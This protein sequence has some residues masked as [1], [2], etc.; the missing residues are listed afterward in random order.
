[1]SQSTIA[2]PTRRALLT[3]AAG[4]CLA[5]FL[6][7]SATA[8]DIKLT[9]APAKVPLVVGQ[10]E[11]AV[12]AYNGAVPGPEIRVR[13]GERV[14]V[15]V[16]NRL[17]EDTTVHWHG[18]RVPNAMDGVPHLTQTPIAAA[19]ERSCTSSTCRTRAPTG[20]TR[21]SAAPSRSVAASSGALI[22]EER[23]PI[24]SIATSCGCS[25]TGG[26][27]PTRQ[28][29]DDFGNMHDKA[30]NG[31][32]G[33]TVTVNGRVPEHVLGAPRRAHQA[34]A[35]QRR[36][37]PHLRPEV[38]RSSAHDHRLRRP[39]RRRRTRRRRAPSCWGPPCAST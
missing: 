2:R 6:P 32:V 18:V 13:Q 4:A 14:R 28:I 30:H 15:A 27:L 38:R 33:N 21:T 39:A 23:E 35:H 11:T 10:P 19:A 16:E 9:A 7:R 3:G 31:R 26:L 36:Q 17:A 25:R 34:A 12:W 20:T 5:G 29:S 22:V 24:R 1:M 37:R 8:A